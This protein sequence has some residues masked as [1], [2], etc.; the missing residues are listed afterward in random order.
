[1]LIRFEKH[2]FSILSH[3]KGILPCILGKPIA[4]YNFSEFG[5]APKN[6]HI[7]FGVV[8]ECTLT[9]YSNDALGFPRNGF[10]YEAGLFCK[11]AFIRGAYVCAEW[12]F[13]K[14]SEEEYHSIPESSALT[15]IV[16]WSSVPCK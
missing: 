8:S 5:Y 13:R 14:S 2:H 7:E 4:F 15:L 1:V 16:G 11:Y 6:T 10:E 12:T 9:A 3:S